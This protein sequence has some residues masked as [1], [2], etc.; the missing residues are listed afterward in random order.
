[1]HLEGKIIEG[2]SIDGK[3]TKGRVMLIYEDALASG[4]NMYVGVTYLLVSDKEG[5]THVVRPR[6]VQ[7]ITDEY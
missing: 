5:D 7:K 2:T 1:M 6:D 3:S 4:T